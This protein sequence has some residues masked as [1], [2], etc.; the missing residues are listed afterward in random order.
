M[1]SMP[2][3]LAVL[4]NS[5][6]ATEMQRERSACV[7]CVVC[8]GWTSEAQAK[9]KGKETHQ[10]RDRGIQPLRL[11]VDLERLRVRNSDIATA[12]ILLQ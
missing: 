6:R 3:Q 1:S 10:L 11:R 7:V 5:A 2:N 8:I 4:T 9:R 12:T